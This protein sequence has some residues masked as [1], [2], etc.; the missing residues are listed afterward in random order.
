MLTSL[1]GLSGVEFRFEA[2]EQVAMMDV[3]Q[4]SLGG[5]E[6]NVRSHTQNIAL[7]GFSF[8]QEFYVFLLR[9]DYHANA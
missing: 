3:V 5:M 9:N 4:Y 8:L 6:D 7:T 1:L 2:T